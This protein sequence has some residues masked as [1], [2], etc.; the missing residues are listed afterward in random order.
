[1]QVNVYN[2]LAASEKIPNTT[3]GITVIQGAVEI[4]LEAG[5]KAGG[6]KPNSTSTEVPTE[7]DETSFD[8][9][10]RTLSGVKFAGKLANAIH[11]VEI[12]G[13]VTN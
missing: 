10:T 7:D 12:T 8:A 3:A 6:F 11:A 2:K 1:M 4:T 5:T 9:T 13:E